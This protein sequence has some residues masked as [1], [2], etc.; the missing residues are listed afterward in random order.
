MPRRSGRR[1]NRRGASLALAAVCMFALIGVGALAIDLGMLYKA[2]A[3]ALYAAEAAALA[4]ASAFLDSP[5]YNGTAVQQ[6]AV[7]RAREYAHN[8]RILTDSI[9]VDAVTVQ[10][11]PAELKVRVRVGPVSIG[12]WF[13]PVF[14]EGSVPVSAVAAAAV[15]EGD[16]VSCVSPFMIPDTWAETA[17]DNVLS[18]GWE[19]S[20]ENWTF[21]AGQGDGYD[22]S[23]NG[24]GSDYRN[25]QADESS[26]QY[27]ADY[28][29]RMIL[30]ASQPAGGGGGTPGRTLNTWDFWAFDEDDPDLEQAVEMDECREGAVGMGENYELITDEAAKDGVRQ[31]LRE[32]MQADNTT[33]WD[34]STGTIISNLPDWRSSSRVIKVGIYNPEMLAALD[35]GGSQV[36]FTNVVLFLLEDVDDQ[37]AISGRFLYYVTG[38][39]SGN[40]D[41]SG[42]SMVKHIRLVE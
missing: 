25:G 37:N 18:N 8:N 24:F 7:D 22:Q 13:A 38:S 39:G 36:P 1:K 2:R 19:D 4:G 40:Q 30:Q 42:G 9:P 28:G 14:D 26:D 10:V 23:G 32:R 21:D 29:R 6:E 15:E 34:P 17:E 33:R 11:I 3:D 20:A 16:D 5:N 41:E 35:A 12:T 31:R 27:T